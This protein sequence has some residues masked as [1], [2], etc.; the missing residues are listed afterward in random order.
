MGSSWLQVR[1]RAGRVRLWQRWYARIAST[2]PGNDFV[3]FGGRRSPLSSVTDWA[4]MALGP[5]QIEQLASRLAGRMAEA[6]GRSIVVVIEGIGELLDTEADM[7]LQALLRA[8][9]D[10]GAFVIAEGETSTLGGSW[11]LL[12]AV[13][14]HRAG[15]ALRPDQMDGDT[16]FKTPFPRTAQAEFP[17][18]RGLLVQSGTVTK[19]QVA[20]PE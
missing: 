1:P 13:K 15:I 11:P 14:S 6:V 20:L 9:R 3:L 7:P 4:A 8:C 18:G 10:H 16:L 12:Q 17:V 2:R 5:A 19:V